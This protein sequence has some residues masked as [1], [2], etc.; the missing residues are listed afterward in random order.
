[1]RLEK[2]CN[3]DGGAP[4]PEGAFYQYRGRCLPMSVDHFRETVLPKPGGVGG[5]AVLDHVIHRTR[6]G[7]VQGWTTSGD[8]PVAIVRQRSTYNHDI[9]SVVGFLQWGQPALTHDVRSWMKGA[10]R[11]LY[12]FNWLYVDSR[13][14]GYFVSG[15]DPIRPSNIDPSLPTWG[16]GDSEWQGYL[17]P[18]QH[19]HQVDPAQGYFVS[20]NNKPA[21]GFAAADDQ[22]GYGQVFRSVLLTRA[23]DAQLRLHGGKLTRSQVVYAMETAAS[24]DLDG[25]TVIT[26]LQRYLGDRNEPADVQAMLDALH[27][28][29]QY[30]SHRRK[31]APG[32]TEYAHAAAVAISDELMPNLIRALYDPILLDG[33]L[34]TVGSTG[35]ATATGYA[36]L[37]QQFV[38]TPNSGGAHLGSAYDG[39]YE[40]YVVA[41]LQQLMGRHPVDGFGPEITARECNGGPATCADAI[42]AALQKTFTD[43]AAVNGT[44]DVASWTQSTASHDA[45]QTMP[46]FDAI[47]FRALGVV[48]QPN[49]DWQN[50]PTFQQVVEFPRHR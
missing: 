34:G 47:H 32:D 8:A 29:T 12:T 28:W 40:S 7:I 3:P 9:D 26:L 1:M 27:T 15:R 31:T 43:L 24:Q 42:D 14:T 38:N 19:V 33:G 2:I 25:V 6:H 13:N 48:G 11:I 49:I 10:A 18:G 30:G 22:Y 35:G 17:T 50:R 16:T 23:L 4:D 39:G 44:T 20:W 36:A 5:P 37:P 46:V 45:G 21:P 41:T